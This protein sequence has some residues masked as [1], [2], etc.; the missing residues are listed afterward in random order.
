M[1]WNFM[2]PASRDNLT[3]AWERE[4]EGFFAILEDLDAWERPTAAGHWQVRDV[5]GHLVD[6]TE[7]YFRSFDA[8]RGIGEPFEPL[9]VRDMARHV[10]EGAQG[11]R[12]VPREDLIERLRGDLKRFRGIM[13]DVSDDE[14]TGFTPVHKHMGPLPA[15]FYPL[16]QLVDYGVHS[17][18]MRHG[19]G[20]SHGLD[21]RTADLLAP[22]AFIL[23]QS[24]TE[25]PDD[26][27]PF[28]VG[29]RVT[30]GENAGDTR[31]AVTP[32]GLQT[33]PGDVG[34]LPVVIEFDPGSLVLTSYG[35]FN[36]GTVHGD[37]ALADRYLNLFFRI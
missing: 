12:S 22:L 19:I 18:D 6:T 21:N 23:W 33:E 36:G 11:L 37:R 3:A 30:S 14:W 2:D 31:V 5:V 8:A 16:F 9:G 28:T 26:L 20:A 7:A 29:V 24:T 25:I 13:D 15:A 10:D 17:W 27:E 35:R 1:S 4:A 34:D 32:E